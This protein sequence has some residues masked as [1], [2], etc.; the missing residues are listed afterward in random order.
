MAMP[1]RGRHRAVRDRRIFKME[2]PPSWSIADSPY[3]F[4]ASGLI[5]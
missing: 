1:R 5:G 3:L 2:T 4:A